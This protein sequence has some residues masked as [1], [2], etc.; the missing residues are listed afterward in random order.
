MPTKS[1]IDILT[2]SDLVNEIQERFL[3]IGH[4]RIKACRFSFHVLNFLN[5]AES[6]GA[7]NIFPY[8]P[9]VE[10]KVLW[11]EFASGNEE[12]IEFCYPI[13]ISQGDNVHSSI[14]LT[15]ETEFYFSINTAPRDLDAAMAQM[16]ASGRAPV[17]SLERCII[18]NTWRGWDKWVKRPEGSP[19]YLPGLWMQIKICRWCERLKVNLA[20]YLCMR[21]T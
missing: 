15:D 2:I 17:H 20:A 1:V 9:N 18:C 6:F 5:A 14:G 21:R 12:W 7:T 11:G 19:D 8:D 10:I 16:L 4:V 3:G 13:L